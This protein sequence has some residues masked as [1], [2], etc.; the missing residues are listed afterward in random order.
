MNRAV[1]ILEERQHRFN[2]ALI[3]R[4]VFILQCCVHASRKCDLE[5][6]RNKNEI[7]LTIVAQGQQIQM[8]PE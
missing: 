2:V 1:N 6:H 7:D 8:T 5:W 4:H 3:T